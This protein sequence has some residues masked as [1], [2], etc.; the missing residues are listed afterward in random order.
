M[1]LFLKTPWPIKTFCTQ[2]PIGYAQRN[3]TKKVVKVYKRLEFTTIGGF[4]YH[5]NKKQH[6]RSKY[7]GQNFVT[8]IICKICCPS[9]KIACTTNVLLL[10]Y[11]VTIKLDN[12]FY[13]LIGVGWSLIF[14]RTYMFTRLRVFY[15]METFWF[16]ALIKC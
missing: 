13:F 5:I 4:F 1:R 7:F 10:T 14:R 2:F 15:K 16:Q 3:I 6:V 8:L 9:S 11:K 12:N